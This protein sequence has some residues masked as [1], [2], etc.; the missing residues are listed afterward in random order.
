MSTLKGSRPSACGWV[1]FGLLLFASSARADPGLDWLLL[2]QRADGSYGGSG[3]SLAIPLQTTAEVL[4][5][6]ARLGQGNGLAFDAALGF[7]NSFAESN[8]EFLSRKIVAN[9]QGGASVE[10]WVAEL[11]QAQT[12]DGGFGDRPGYAPSTYD[13]AF[14]V[15]ALAFA[16]DEALA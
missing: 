11:M 16:K 3:S 9:V 7:V 12:E 13:T 10:A 5:A 1:L 4:R 2:Q 8:T 14:A 15:E 6:Q